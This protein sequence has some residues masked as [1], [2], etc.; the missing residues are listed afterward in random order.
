MDHDTIGSDEV[1]GTLMLK[2]KEIIEDVHGTN[3]KFVWHNIYGAPLGHSTKEAKL[4]NDDPEV[5][6]DWKGRVLL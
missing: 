5:A 4:M 1:G 3:G 6:S 2:T